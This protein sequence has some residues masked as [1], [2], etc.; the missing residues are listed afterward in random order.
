M[1]ERIIK[2][3]KISYKVLKNLIQNRE[4]LKL[5]KKKKNS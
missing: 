1:L 3:F 2:D 4:Y 5:K